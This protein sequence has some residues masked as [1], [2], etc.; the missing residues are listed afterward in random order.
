MLKTI[1][2]TG[3]LTW[4]GMD[5]DIRNRV[6]FSFL[7]TQPTLRP[8]QEIFI[9]YVSKFPRS[10]TENSVL[11]IYVDVFSKFVWLLPVRD[12]TTATASRIY[13]LKQ[14]IFATFT[15]PDVVFSDQKIVSYRLIQKVL[16]L[17]RYSTC[18]HYV[19]LPPAFS[20]RK[21]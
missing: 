3:H 16:F 1:Q 17:F 7:A 8:M 21:V 11:T 12:A 2:K 20:C 15:V 18:H 9:D 5:A 14:K 10:K 19:L 6:N 4:K 13:A